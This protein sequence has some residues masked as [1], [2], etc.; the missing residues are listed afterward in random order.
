MDVVP[1]SEGQVRFPQHNIRL[2]SSDQPMD[3]G[4]FRVPLSNRVDRTDPEPR[5]KRPMPTRWDRGFFA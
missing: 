1:F 4:K 5:G 3:C 2:R